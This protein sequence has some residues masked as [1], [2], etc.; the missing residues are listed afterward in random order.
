MI[1]VVDPNERIRLG[2]TRAL[3]L[4]PE[5]DTREPL[6]KMLQKLDSMRMEA[7]IQSMA[8]GGWK[9]VDT[10]FTL[11]D[12]T[13]VQVS[14]TA[15][16]IL[17]NTGDPRVTDL[18]L[19]LLEQPGPRDIRTIIAALGETKDARAVE[20]L[21][22][23]A[24]D[25]VKRAGKE[26]ELGEALAGMGEPKAAPVIAQMIKNSSSGQAVHRLKKAYKLIT[27]KEYQQRT[28]DE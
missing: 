14:R 11:A 22:R 10:L 28:N 16:S 25:P 19:K 17:G 23:M 8:G 15:I 1:G 6:T 26:P 2:S 7:V 27:G 20:P 21:L 5:E 3:S 12:S 13:D 24:S 9:P 18:L 4:F